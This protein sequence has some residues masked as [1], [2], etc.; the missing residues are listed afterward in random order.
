MNVTIHHAQGYSRVD[1]FAPEIIRRAGE[2]HPNVAA[3]RAAVARAIA[4][5]PEACSVIGAPRIVWTRDNK[6]GI[7]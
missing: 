3:A 6:T 1:H 5:M 4:E 2:R 7:I